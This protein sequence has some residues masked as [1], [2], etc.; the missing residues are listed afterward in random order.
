[1]INVKILTGRWKQALPVLTYALCKLLFTGRMTKISGRS[2]YIVDISF[3]I[4]IFR[5]PRSFFQNGFMTS[6]LKDPS[7][8]K[9]QRTEIAASEAASVAGQAEFDLLQCRN[10]AIFLIHWMILSCIGKIIHIIHFCL[11]QR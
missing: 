11:R 2:S 7:L 4:R 6:G 9:G 5:H 3:K 10:S 8:M 1:M